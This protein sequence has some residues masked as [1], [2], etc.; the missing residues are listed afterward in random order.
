MFGSMG[1]THGY[2]RG[3][4]LRGKDAESANSHKNP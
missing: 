4:P 3:F 2:S 1:F